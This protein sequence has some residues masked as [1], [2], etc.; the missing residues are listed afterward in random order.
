MI[1]ACPFHLLVPEVKSHEVCVFQPQWFPL[2]PSDL[3]GFKWANGRKFLPTLHGSEWKCKKKN[4]KSVPDLNEPRLGVGVKPFWNRLPA[5]SPAKATPDLKRGYLRSW[6]IGI[7][8][9]LT[10]AS[11][12]DLSGLSRL[13]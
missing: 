4:L 1:H 13:C 10:S 6:N 11:L 12:S 3:A 8:N 5:L 7:G 9:P 2:G